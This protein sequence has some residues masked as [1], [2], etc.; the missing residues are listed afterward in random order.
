MGATTDDRMSSDR[1]RQ[2]AC[3]TNT[4][5]SCLKRSLSST[6]PSPSSTNTTTKKSNNKS[7]RFGGVE[8]R[9]RR[10]PCSTNASDLYLTRR[11]I[12]IQRREA[13]QQTRQYH[14]AGCQERLALDDVHH[15]SSIPERIFSIVHLQ[16]T[17]PGVRGLEKDVSWR[18][19]ERVASHKRR[20][21]RAV[22]DQQQH[23]QGKPN[24]HALAT[25]QLA[26]A[27]VTKSHSDRVMARVLA[28]ADQKCV[29]QDLKQE[30]EETQTAA[31]PATNTA[32][33]QQQPKHVRKGSD[34]SSTVVA[35]ADLQ[36]ESDKTLSNMMR[37]IGRSLSSKRVTSSVA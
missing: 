21:T 36:K 12:S 32:K 30:Q 23:Q 18:Y 19:G 13:K 34:S 5:I 9:V 16:H 6:M 10:F 28:L 31:C 2:G 35:A 27:S 8:T 26:A 15:A 29:R 7:V 17:A 3:I 4:K 37:R 11:E 24:C 14:Y 22:L 20:T 1:G 33:V 25:K